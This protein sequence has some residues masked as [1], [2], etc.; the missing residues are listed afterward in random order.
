[1]T[2]RVVYYKSGYKYQ[3]TR[4]FHVQLAIRPRTPICT[5][6]LSLDEN[7]LLVIKKG[8]AWD[9]ASG[10]TW[11]TKNSMRGSL[12]HDAGYQL[13]RLGLLDPDTKEY[14]DH[15]L[16][17]LMVEDGMWDWRANYWRWA[18]LEFG[19]GSTRPS[20]EPQEECAP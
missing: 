1:M 4:D 13:I 7:G 3:T 9:G 10:P 12:V 19:A 16:H 15:L 5:E 2:D 18:V 11:D 8:Y 6:Y 20:A 17:D 14:F